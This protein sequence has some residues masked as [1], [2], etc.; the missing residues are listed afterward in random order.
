MSKGLP[1]PISQAG[2]GKHLGLVAPRIRFSFPKTPCFFD[3]NF[4]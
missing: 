2:K 4:V 1:F 3:F